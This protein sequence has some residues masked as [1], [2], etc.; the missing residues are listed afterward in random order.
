ML[1]AGIDLGSEVCKS[2]LMDDEVVLVSNLCDVGYQ[3]AS[4]VCAQSLETLLKKSAVAADKIT[5]IGCT[6]LPFENE[7]KT[8]ARFSESLCLARGAAYCHHSDGVLLDMGSGKSTAVGFDRMGKPRKMVRTGGCASGTGE[9]LSVL[10]RVLDIR[11][12]DMGEIASRSQREIGLL[13]NCTVFAE[14]EVISLL[15]NR[16][17]AE[18][19]AAAILREMANQV[20]P[21]IRQIGFYKN[22]VLTGGAAGNLFLAEEIQR[23]MDPGVRI[24]F[25]PR[26]TAAVGAALA[27]REKSIF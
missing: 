5:V 11:V 19:I 18:D 27:A 14:S 20:C 10:A 8:V 1:Y 25:C 9:F 2:V 24:L 17:S 7:G 6:G 23:R 13:S 16:I 15:H 4:L 21:L 26:E 22:V 3:D 12:E